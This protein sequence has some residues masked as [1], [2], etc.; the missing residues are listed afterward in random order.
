MQDIP[1]D[2]PQQLPFK[3]SSIFGPSKPLLKGDLLP[4]LPSSFCPEDDQ[5]HMPLGGVNVRNSQARRS[6]SDF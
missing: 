6:S 1:I 2:H 3:C 4:H 5:A